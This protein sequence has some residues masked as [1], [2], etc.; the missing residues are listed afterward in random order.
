[1]QDAGKS[2]SSKEKKRLEKLSSTF[3][4]NAGG[5]SAECS[6]LACFHLWEGRDTA[7]GEKKTSTNKGLTAVP[8]FS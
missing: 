7:V 5:T 8:V 3:W 4:K 6:E 1:M 2:F